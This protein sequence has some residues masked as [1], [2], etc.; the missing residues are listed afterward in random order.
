MPINPGDDLTVAGDVTLPGHSP[1]ATDPDVREAVDDL[2]R[3]A[4]MPATASE[5]DPRSLQ[6][7]LTPGQSFGG[8]YHIIRLLGIG[9][10]GAVYQAW[11]EELG[12]I[13]ALKVIRPEAA[14]DPEAALALERRFKQELLLAR[15]VTHKNVV[16][17]HDLGEVRGIKYITMPFI[18]G[19]DLG[20]IIERE[21]PLPLPRVLK[22]ARTMASGLAA[23]QAAGVVHRDL[24]PANIM[25]DSDG[26]SLITDFG[27]ARST[28]ARPMPEAPAGRA[29]APMAG[30]T[31]V[32]AIVGTV[33]YMAP[34][35]AQALPVD[36]RADIY[37]AGLIIYD[38]LGGRQR[39][40]RAESVIAELTSRTLAP[41]PSLTTINPAVPETI[42][43]IVRR[44][45]QP[46]PGARYATAQELLA[47]LDQLDDAG[48]RHRLPRHLTWKTKV[49]AAMVFAAGLS[50][51][52]WAAQG[53]A[54][55]AEPTPIS[56]LIADFENTTGDPVFSG[57]VEQA[58]GIAIEGASFIDA[59]SRTDA[60]KVAEQLHPGAPIDEKMAHLIAKRE[61][62]NVILAG[63]IQ[64]DGS[65]FALAVR[66]IDPAKGEQGPPLATVRATAKD[67]SAVLETVAR[68]ASSLRRELGDTASA[69]DREKPTE[70]FTAASIDA[71]RAYVRGQDLQVAGKLPEALAAYQEAVSFDP[72]FGRAYNG[73]AGVYSNLKQSD[74]TE[75]SFQQAVKYLNRMTEREKFATLGG[76]YLLISKNY[77]KAIENYEALVSKYP[78]DRG[79]VANLALAYLYVRDVEKAVAGVRKALALEPTNHLQRMNYAMYS[80]YAGDFKTAI[81][82]SRRMPKDSWLHAIGLFTIARAAAAAGDKPTAEAAV[83]ELGAAGGLGA[84]LATMTR[85]DMAIYSGRY[86]EAIGILRTSAAAAEKEGD[87]DGAAGNLLPLAEALAARGQR[88]EAI[89]A[90]ARAV[91]LTSA[92]SV[93]F[94]AGMLL[95]EL[96]E[97]R[98][99]EAIAATLDN[100]LQTQTRSYAGLITAQLALQRKRLP[101]AMQTFGES[102]RRFDSWFAR[103]LLAR[104][105]FE[106]KQYPEALAEFELCLK[107]KGELTDVFFTDSS[108]LRYLPQ[109]YYWLGRA[110]EALQNPEARENYKRYIDIREHTDAP[111][112]LLADAKAR[113]QV[114]GP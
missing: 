79:G 4:G 67:K 48:R 51:T 43:Q 11:D 91:E 102:Q 20:T 62:L 53:T 15:Q 24:K 58:L 27:I 18:D 14:T 34:E 87:R 30:H 50:V 19:E 52:W 98:R 60:R 55:I 46:D 29:V 82:E 105:S 56:V 5:S 113:L 100:Q 89:A 33:Q 84:S 17:I 16:R 12:V 95:L 59:Y 78:A 37:A 26:E 83:G 93:L 2:T 77:E 6:G 76:Y 101:D 25:I 74:K 80:M 65:R 104:A 22:I 112:P 7:P 21:G 38:M 54:P 110:Q 32:G 114:P 66:A 41:P 3:I 97:P 68:L 108:T 90:A 88:S 44:C 13:V 42:D 47:D 75:E 45:L 10:M 63:S 94:P 28:G 70:T 107:R 106:A 57:A 109:V 8:R 85:A 92:E 49:A 31:V 72:A 71:M 96:G 99:A 111:D 81:E 86:Q 36:H 64:P 61:A 73:M 39:F 103:W 23:A 69:S 40:E 35:Q 1:P 9:G